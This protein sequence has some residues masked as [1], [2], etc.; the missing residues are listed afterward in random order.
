MELLLLFAVV[1][2]ISLFLAPLCSCPDPDEGCDGSTGV[3]VVT[4]GAADAGE[5]GKVAVTADAGD[6][7]LVLSEF[8]LGLLQTDKSRRRLALL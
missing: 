8:G 7:V 6:A 3:V 2:G 1:D 5:E 4:S